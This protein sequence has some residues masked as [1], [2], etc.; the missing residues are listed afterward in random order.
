MA[1]RRRFHRNRK[2]RW[3]PKKKCWGATVG[4][5]LTAI[6][7][8][9]DKD[10]YFPGHLPQAEADQLVNQKSQQWEVICRDWHR[11]SQPL[12]QAFGEPHP[13][14]PRWNNAPLG[15]KKRKLTPEQVEELRRE[16]HITEE[17]LNG[18]LAE[19][20]LRGFIEFFRDERA[21]A[22]A[23]KDGRHTSLSKLVRQMYTAVGYF[24]DDIPARELRTGHFVQAKKK[25]HAKLARRTVRNY[26]S[27]AIELLR[28]VY[29][30]YMNGAS[31]PEGI[32]EAASV[33]KA[34]R[35]DIRI[36]E[37]PEIEQYLRA[38]KGTLSQLD[39]MLGLNCGMYPQDIGRLER[40][41]V[42]CS[43]TSVFW[44]RE[45]EPQNPFR[46]H[47]IFWAETLLL[48]RRFLNN[49]TVI[50]SPVRD[51]R[52]GKE[53]PVLLDPAKLALLDNGKPRYW[54]TPSGH[55][56]NWVSKRMSQ[57]AKGV[58]FQ[59]LRKTTNQHL[60]QLTDDPILADALSKHF[61]GQ[62]TETLVRLY[63]LRGKAAYTQ[64]N[65]Y[66]GKLGDQF[67]ATGLFKHIR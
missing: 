64:M 52:H 1:R 22:V 53:H 28:F 56:K 17:E 46:I 51:Y 30:K 59:D 58:S 6:G 36:Y 33:P 8:L 13:D 25:M 54:N 18:V 48:I 12:L 24:P 37:F 14:E 23:R 63:S 41:E 42:D 15:Q 35:T 4:Q 66:L 62:K 55:E 19:Y 67:R 60:M 38:T 49:G 16:N 39:I 44:D 2:A 29:A 47:H 32:E 50:G 40:V 65:Q 7:K 9:A 10:W 3:L 34:T 31:L 45:K 27:A 61:L 11:T 21:P 43:D 5:S 57:F 20:S 26:M